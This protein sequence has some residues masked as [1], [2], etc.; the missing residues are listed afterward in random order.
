MSKFKVG[1]R[2]SV[3]FGI[4][5]GRFGTITNVSGDD[6]TYYGLK[7]DCHDKEV[8]YCEYELRDANPDVPAWLLRFE[9]GNTDLSPFAARQIAEQAREWLLYKRA[10]ESMSAQMIYPKMTAKEMAELQ[11]SKT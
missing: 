3:K 7:L 11:L 4:D 1:D 6:G 10:F 9:N 2:V 8:G 5:A